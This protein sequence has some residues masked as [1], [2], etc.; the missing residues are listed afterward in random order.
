LHDEALPHLP[1]QFIVQ[2]NIG[3]RSY[4]R[5]QEIERQLGE[6]DFGA[7]ALQ[8]LP[9]DIQAKV[10]PEQV[11]LAWMSRGLGLRGWR[12]FSP[13][14]LSLRRAMVAQVFAQIWAN[15]QQR[16]MQRRPACDK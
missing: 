16:F 14:F 5:Q 1:H 11:S 6:R 10:R 15:L 4:E 12:H 9:A 3:S 8:P 13:G 2:D 7:V